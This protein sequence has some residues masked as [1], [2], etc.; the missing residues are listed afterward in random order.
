MRVSYFLVLL[1]HVYFYSK[2]ILIGEYLLGI[3]YITMLLRLWKRGKEDRY[4]PCS[5]RAQD[6]QALDT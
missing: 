2:K 6:H 3:Y 1:N 5:H 4:G